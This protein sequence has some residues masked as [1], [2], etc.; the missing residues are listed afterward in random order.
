MGTFSICSGRLLRYTSFQ[1]YRP[2]L[3]FVQTSQKSPNVTG[4]VTE[5]PKCKGASQ[6]QRDNK[7]REPIIIDFQCETQVLSAWKQKKNNH[8]YVGA[9]GGSTWAGFNVK[10]IEPPR[11]GLTELVGRIWPAIQQ[12]LGNAWYLVDIQNYHKISKKYWW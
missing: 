12:Q 3:F 5:R 4:L 2:L 9:F 6:R 7:H 11:A 10:T 8:S 1:L